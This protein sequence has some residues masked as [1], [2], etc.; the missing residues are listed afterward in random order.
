MQL[1]KDIIRKALA[2]QYG[3]TFR[4]RVRPYSSGFVLD[5]LYGN[6]FDCMYVCVG[7]LTPSGFLTVYD[8]TL[9]IDEENPDEFKVGIEY[10][11]VRHYPLEEVHTE[12]PSTAAVELQVAPHTDPQTA[13]KFFPAMMKLRY[14][15]YEVIKVVFYKDGVTAICDNPEGY[16]HF[17]EN[18]M[19]EVPTSY[20]VIYQH[21]EAS[22]DILGVLPFNT[23]IP[24]ERKRP[25]LKIVK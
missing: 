7:Q 9:E 15:K 16:L 1:T 6:S 3:E 22:F 8:G 14:P 4:C 5:M 10:S 20:E 25:E 19:E 21:G 24:V 23:S 11:S 13:M 2:K 18:S 12:A 17:R